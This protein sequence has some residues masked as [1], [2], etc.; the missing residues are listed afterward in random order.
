MKKSKKLKMGSDTTLHKAQRRLKKGLAELRA[1]AD[2]QAADEAAGAST[3]SGDGASDS[4]TVDAPPPAKRR[5]EA[6]EAVLG[7]AFEAATTREVRRRL[8]HTQAM[9]AVVVVPNANWVAPAKSHV[10]SAFGERWIV[11]AR[12]GSDRRQDS[13][14]GSL[15]VARELSRGR[16]VM[17]VAADERLLP[18]ALTAAADVVVRIAPPDGRVLR[19]AI[20]RFAGRSP[21]KVP[22]AVAAGLDLHEILA[23]FRP[24]TGARTIVARLAAAGA[25]RRETVGARVPDLATAVEYGEARTWGLALA[26]DI[27]DYRA[28][29][30]AWRDVDRGIVLHSAPG[31][32]KSLF[33]QVLARACNVPLVATSVGELF[34]SS[35]G[36]LDSVIKAVR[37][38]FARASALAPCILFLDEIDALPDRATM[39]PRGRDWWM[40]VVTDFLIQLDS[41]VGQREGIVVV[42]ATN[43]IER[44]DTALLRPGRLEKSVEIARPDLAGTI[45]ILRFHVDGGV[46]DGD[47]A[48]VGALLEGATGA[49][50]MHI[51]RQARRVARHA[52]RPMTADDLRRAALPVE[53]VPPDRLFRMAVHEAAHAV[54][55]LAIPVGRL[56]HV[57]LR[58]RGTSGGQ[59]AIDFGGF[60]LPT[61]RAIEDRVVV[62]LAARAAERILLGSVSTGGG[63]SAE[64]D[65]GSATAMVAAVHASFGMGE[66]CVYLGAGEELLREISLNP[67]LRR[68]V[69]LHLRELDERAAAL[70]ER[71]RAAILAVAERLAA[72]RFL[73]GTEVAGIVAAAR[74]AAPADP[75]PVAP[76]GAEEK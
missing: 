1:V 6:A 24:G 55:A 37:A 33:A 52:G 36:Y 66:D 54:T 57:A 19:A 35:A 48:G 69:A 31:F 46:P 49:E 76:Q 68:T 42:G 70:V 43:A 75:A 73:G 5:P 7:A 12:D 25:A 38:A 40:P 61:R 21:G 4:D 27:A 47:L 32:G 59:T 58:S 20:A 9:A 13:S 51:A 34:A 64:S 23:A 41:A 2:A 67:G 10:G 65:L 72:K 16:C 3:A 50:I 26:R 62:G 18:A 56:K 14:T 60:V 45:N 22:D 15:D 29:R 74:S 17:G 11:H 53:D 30:I 44:V 28:G 8:R 39:S 71:E 63:G